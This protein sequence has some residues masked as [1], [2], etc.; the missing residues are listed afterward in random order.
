MGRNAGE[1]TVDYAADAF[2]GD[3]RFRD[4]GG[5]DE[6][7]LLRGVDREV[8][9][10]CRKLPV[11]GSDRPVVGAGEVFTGFAASANLSG[12]R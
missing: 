2:N 5:E 8:L 7:A 9:L 11:Q 4:I 1:P 3:G 10:R 6:L 12:P